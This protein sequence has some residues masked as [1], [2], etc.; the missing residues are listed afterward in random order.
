[1]KTGPL[2]VLRLLAR[3]SSCEGIMGFGAFD[4]R[5]APTLV[6]VTFRVTIAQILR[7]TSLNGLT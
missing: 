6:A 1:V 4:P 7:S 2:D 5:Q 3:D